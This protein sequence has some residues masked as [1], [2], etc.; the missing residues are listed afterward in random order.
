MARATIDLEKPANLAIFM[1]ALEKTPKDIL[2]RTILDEAQKDEHVA[3]IFWDAL[4]ST[5]SGS[6]SKNKAGAKFDTCRHC[7]KGFDITKNKKDS[8]GCAWHYGNLT[9]DE[10]VWVEYSEIDQGPIDSKENRKL[11]PQG[12]FW[13]CCGLQLHAAGCLKTEHAPHTVLKR[14]GR[15]LEALESERTTARWS[16]GIYEPGRDAGGP[17]PSK[18]RKV[19]AS[20][21]TKCRTCG[22]MYNEEKNTK[23]ACHWH[24]LDA[25]RRFT[26]D[27]E[28][29][30]SEEDGDQVYSE[31]EEFQDE[32]GEP[33]EGQTI[34]WTCCGSDKEG[35]CVVT[36]HLPPRMTLPRVKAIV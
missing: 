29:W 7:K 32:D 1:T 8:S 12:F 36:P 31:N 20:L 9:V 30:D 23:R 13:D 35:G 5:E 17:S 25:V 34:Q 22:E 2:E 10:N 18:K 27:R 15:V 3:K 6:S 33:E 14:N 21:Q 24:D 28:D 11:W 16:H 4:V 26:G 19:D